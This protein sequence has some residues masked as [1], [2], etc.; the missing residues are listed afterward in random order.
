VGEI[1]PSTYLLVCLSVC[2][3]VRLSICWFV[4]G[5]LS[6]RSYISKTTFHNSLNFLFML[7]VAEARS[8]SDDSTIRHEL[9]ILWTTSCFHIGLMGLKSS[10]TLFCRIRQMAVRGGRSCCQITLDSYL[11]T[12]LLSVALKCCCTTWNIKD[13][14]ASPYTSTKA[15]HDGFSVLLSTSHIIA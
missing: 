14:V 1:L 11:L 2:L 10:A 4:C 7:A 12:N 13:L 6:V 15:S 3:S 8:S 5:S 9:P